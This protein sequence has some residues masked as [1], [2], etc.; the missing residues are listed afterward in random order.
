MPKHTPSILPVYAYDHSILKEKSVR[1]EAFDA[2]LAAFVEAMMTTMHNADGIGLAANQVGDRRAITTIDISDI[3]DPVTKKPYKIPPMVLINPMIEAFSEETVE[4][5][6]GCL[7]LPQYRDDV[8]RPASIQIRFHDVNMGE[9][10]MAATGLLA[11]VM[12]H[13]V[14]HLNGI[15]FFEH[16]SPIRKAMGFQKLRRIQLGQVQT[17]Y[18]LFDTKSVPAAKL[19]KKK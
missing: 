17:S 2:E 12:Q 15:Y 5:E 16:L 10:R 9:H 19:R 13:E 18:P 11:R 6:E 7:S 3:D 4:M 1:V 8:V 14:D